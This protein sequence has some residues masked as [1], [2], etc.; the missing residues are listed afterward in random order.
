MYPNE[1]IAVYS[2]QKFI[3]ELINNVGISWQLAS[4]LVTN[5]KVFETEQD[6]YN[7]CLQIIRYDNINTCFN[8]T[9]ELRS[10]HDA[11]DLLRFILKHISE[12]SGEC[13]SEQEKDIIQ[14]WAE[15]NK[16]NVFFTNNYVVHITL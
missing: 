14:A 13:M 12:V 6:T 5:T 11:A 1:I 9:E 16:F 2:F 15:C 8:I 4:T 3:N 7:K 10:I